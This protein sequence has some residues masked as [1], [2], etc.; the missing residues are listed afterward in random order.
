MKEVKKQEKRCHRHIIE[1]CFDSEIQA[2]A[3]G[4]QIMILH[5]VIKLNGDVAFHERTAMRVEALTTILEARRRSKDV[6]EK[7]GLRLAVAACDAMEEAFIDDVKDTHGLNTEM[8]FNIAQQAK[9]LCEY[10]RCHAML[11][12][13][14]K[15]YRENKKRKQ[16]RQIIKAA[17]PELPEILIGRLKTDERAKYEDAPSELALQHTANLLGLQSYSRRQLKRFLKEWKER[18]PKPALLTQFIEKIEETVTQKSTR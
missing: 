18:Y 4:K 9:F 5:Q 7:V 8:P 2:D 3:G 14:R 11:K 17:Y 16:W 10:E 6:A 13:A 15:L 12:D 1:V